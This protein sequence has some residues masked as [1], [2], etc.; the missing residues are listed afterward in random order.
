MKHF[1]VGDTMPEGARGY[2]KK[3]VVWLLKM[4]EP[5]TCDN[6]EGNHMQGQ[7]GD[8]LADDG[9]DGFYPISAEFHTANYEDADKDPRA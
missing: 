9:Q 8:F 3:T 4:D 7:A 5:F 6:R 2:K 1:G